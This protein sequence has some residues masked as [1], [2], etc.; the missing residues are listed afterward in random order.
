MRTDTTRLMNHPPHLLNDGVKVQIALSVFR[1]E[2]SRVMTFLFLGE[3]RYG[4]EEEEEE[5]EIERK[6]RGVG[7]RGGGGEKEEDAIEEGK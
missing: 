7:G 1:F 4:R 6:E 5:E 3:C 2:S